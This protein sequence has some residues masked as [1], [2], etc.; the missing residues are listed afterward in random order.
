M[1]TIVVSREG[2]ANNLRVKACLLSYN[3]HGRFL[4]EMKKKKKRSEKSSNGIGFET[5]FQG[6]GSTVAEHTLIVFFSPFKQRKRNIAT[7]HYY[8]F[9]L[10][11]FGT[12]L[13]TAH[14]FN[15]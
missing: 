10:L 15:Y 6:T 13:A 5:I 4:C 8:D 12:V 9:V 2:H 1:T 14:A 7:K 3:L 11:H